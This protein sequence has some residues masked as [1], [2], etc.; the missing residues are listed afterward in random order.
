MALDSLIRKGV[1]IIDKQTKSVQSTIL[2][3]Q[4]V[5]QD[6]FGNPVYDPP[7]GIRRKAILDDRYQLKTMS[8]GQTIAIGATL[9]FL[10]Y[11]PPQGSDKR[12]VEPL[13]PKDVIVLPDGSEN[14]IIKVFGLEDPEK[15]RPFALEVW[16]GAK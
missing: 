11:I 8:D 14:S 9:L 2:H 10:E 15:N 7:E 3:K 4:W 5:D 6:G 13:D 16:L 1:K 12:S